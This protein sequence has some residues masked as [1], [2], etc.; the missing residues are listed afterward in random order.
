MSVVPRLLITMGDVAGIGPEV[1]A[2]AWPELIQVAEPVV[3]GD[4]GWLRRA[5]DL[6]GS[7]TVV[8]EV[9]APE[10]AQPTRDTIPCLAG[11]DQDVGDVVPGRVTAA[12]GR[13]AYDFLCTAIDLT[14]AGR[15]DGIVTAPLHKEGLR[16]AGLSYPGHTEILA[17]RTGTK[18][19]AMMLYVNGLGVAH[20]TLH[21]ALRDVFR[22]LSPSAV[23]EK[24]VLTDGVMRRLLGRDVRVGV[25]ALNPHASD[26]GLFGDEEERII[27][28]AVEAARLAGIDASGPWPCDTLFVRA[29]KG[30][31]DG[32]VAI[33]HDQGHI[34]LKLLGGLRAVNISV[35]LPIVRTSVAHGT[36]YDIAGRGVADGTS[37]V[38]A[39][40]VA[41]RL[42]ATRP[43]EPAAI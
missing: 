9:P 26:G 32:V 23:R 33:Y 15:A 28:P 20:V 16:A 38:E 5:L 8:R 34:A 6:I 42:A 35:G 24:I 22:H 41:A 1:I 14:L 13:A 2:R 36:A 37:L 43:R 4:A 7:R 10:V 18:Q 17:E 3:V 27:R 40:R 31:F 39:A 25:A 12:A 29:R 19:F 11:S 21:M 30:D